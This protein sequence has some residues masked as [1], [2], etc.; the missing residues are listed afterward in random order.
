MLTPYFARPATS[1]IAVPA[2]RF[3]TTSRLPAYL[4]HNRSLPQ[5][6]D[7]STTYA[8]HASFSMAPARPCRADDSP[9]PPHAS[10]M[11]NTIQLDARRPA[12]DL[13]AHPLQ[14]APDSANLGRDPAGLAAADAR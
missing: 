2:G 14:L 3:H 13:P 5:T 9:D 8:P 12:L 11:R 1:V 7:L 4:L 10:P 6:R